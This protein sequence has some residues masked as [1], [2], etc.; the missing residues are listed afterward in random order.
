MEV[1]GH[2]ELGRML[3]ND[4]GFS[5]R[6]SA[7]RADN[8]GASTVRAGGRHSIPLVAGAVRLLHGTLPVSLPLSSF[9][10]PFLGAAGGDHGIPRVRAV[11]LAKVT[12]VIAGQV[13]PTRTTVKQP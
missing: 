8:D 6:R 11:A 12:T 3:R 7:R 5:S 4:D 13:K 9:V 10:S 2:H 1:P